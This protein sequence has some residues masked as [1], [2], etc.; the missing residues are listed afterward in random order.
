MLSNEANNLMS[1]IIENEN[2]KNYWAN[3]FDN[4]SPKENAILRGC[5]QE[6]VDN[7]FIKVTWADN[8]PYIIHILKDGYLNNDR[9]EKTAISKLNQIINEGNFL[10]DYNENTADIKNRKDEWLNDAQI[11][12]ENNLKKN[13]LYNRMNT[14]LF[15]RKETAFNELLSCLKSINKEEK[16]TNIS[17]QMNSAS[18]PIL[19]KNYVEY[20]VFISHA[21]ADKEVFVEELHN[22]LK[23]LGI[24]IFYDK[25]S[26]MWGDDWKKKIIDGTNKAEFAIIVISEN[27]FGRE[28]TER[29]LN[30]FLNKQSKTGQKLILPI[31]H[32]IT[33]SQLKEKYPSVANIQAIS[34]SEYSCD[35][36]ALLFA[37]QLIK[38]LKEH[39]NGGS[40]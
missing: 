29:E 38:R 6:L 20:D 12:I 33:I 19:K 11:Y 40:I 1:E 32:N 16:G 36:I 10:S 39:N 3:R 28:W 25:T 17:N 35:Q 18:L 4:I 13:P 9:T 27:F 2:N 34:F 37:G 21:N 30:E 24:E 22:S 31:L 5:F 8:I 15:H 26:L 14:I 7:K 23:K